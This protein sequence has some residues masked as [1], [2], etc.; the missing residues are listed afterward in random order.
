MTIMYISI[1]DSTCPQYGSSLLVLCFEPSNYS[2]DKYFSTLYLPH[3]K[4]KYLFR[5]EFPFRLPITSSFL[6][7]FRL[8]QLSAFWVCNYLE[9][10]MLWS[11][12]TYCL[13]ACGVFFLCIRVYVWR[14]HQY[15]LGW[16]AVFSSFIL[17]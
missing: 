9:K 11:L 16:L 14:Y 12:I 1:F 15:W 5:L 10:N 3:T 4:G 2:S 8:W 17:L 7:T 6:Y 13:G